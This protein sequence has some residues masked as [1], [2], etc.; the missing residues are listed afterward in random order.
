VPSQSPKTET[1]EKEAPTEKSPSEESTKSE[2]LE[3]TKEEP[4]KEEESESSKTEP[5]EANT[6]EGT[7]PAISEPLE[8]PEIEDKEEE[9]KEPQNKYELLE[10]LLKFI[11][12]EEE[13]N[14]VLAGYFSKLVNTFI[15]NSP[16]NAEFLPFVFEQNFLPHF[17]KHIYNRSICENV[18]KL[19]LESVPKLDG[20]MVQ[21][22]KRLL[23]K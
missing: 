4:Q 9:E 5:E 14:H 11:Q 22:K 15:S 19:L 13:V 20:D 1:E 3:E 16:Y 23:I 10:H 21:E 18:T 17:G 12:Q 8:E 6:Q 7:E 2:E